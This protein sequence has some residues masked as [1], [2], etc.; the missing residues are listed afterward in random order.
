MP[1]SGLIICLLA[2]MAS[3]ASADDMLLR[4]SED[5][6]ATM[7]DAAF[8][9]QFKCPEALSSRQSGDA[10]IDF[11]EWVGT[12][13]PAW[14]VADAITARHALLERHR[15]T[16]TLAAIRE[17]TPDTDAHTQSADRHANEEASESDN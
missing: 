13:H 14:T 5:T 4:G 12:R 10:M 6:V 8:D 11:L 3:A 15:C 9:A 2:A 7:N 1:K 16:A 17:N